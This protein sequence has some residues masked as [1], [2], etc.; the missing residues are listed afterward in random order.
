MENLWNKANF[1]KTDEMAEKKEN[2]LEKIKE[3]RKMFLE[4]QNPTGFEVVCDA[5]FENVII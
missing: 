1:Q 5:V 3:T 2:I 4:I